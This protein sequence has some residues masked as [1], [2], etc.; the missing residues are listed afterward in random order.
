MERLQHLSLERLGDAVRAWRDELTRSGVWHSA[1]DA[2]SRVITDTGRH[3]PQ[4]LM[5]QRVCEIFHDAP[6]F[7]EH[8]PGS[9]VPG[10]DA[11]AQ[12]VTTAALLALLVRDA[13]P[14]TTFET[15][16]LPFRD[17]IPADRLGRS[18]DSDAALS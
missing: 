13:L 17:I 11:A 2:V 10:S 12:Y 7:K 3:R 6:W 1:E 15:L 18:S 9:Q 14:N 4:W 8:Q 16:Y 5:L